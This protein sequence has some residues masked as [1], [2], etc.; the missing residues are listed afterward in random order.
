MVTQEGCPSSSYCSRTVTF[1]GHVLGDGGVCHQIKANDVFARAKHR[2][3]CLEFKRQIVVELLVGERSISPSK[4][5]D[6]RPVG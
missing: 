4:A 5:Y 2:T 6:E 3:Y 1:H